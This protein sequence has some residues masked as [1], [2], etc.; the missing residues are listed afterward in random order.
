MSF[1][2]GV[3][4]PKFEFN[5]TYHESVFKHHIQQWKSKSDLKKMILFK[6]S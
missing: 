5:T 3:A 6:V 2:N 1:G 4:T